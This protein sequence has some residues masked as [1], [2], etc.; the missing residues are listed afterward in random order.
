MKKYLVAFAAVGLYTTVAQAENRAGAI[1]LTPVVGGYHY[2][3]TQGIDANI[4]YGLKA[5]Y[6]ITDRFGM[7]ML[8]HYVH[9]KEWS[10]GYGNT[11][12]LVNYRVELLYHLFPQSSFVPFLAVGGGGAR[13][14]FNSSNYD[15]SAVA[16]YGIGANIAMSDTIALRADARM[17]SVFW[18]PAVVYNYEYTL[19]VN[20]QFG[21]TGKA[22]KAIV[23]EPKP[24]PAPAPKLTPPPVA[25]TKQVP[26]VVTEPER[27]TPV[28]VTPPPPAPVP[29]P[30]TVLTADP[31]VI[32]QSASSTLSWTA[33]NTTN[34]ILQPGIGPVAATGSM[35]VTLSVDTTYNLSCKGPGGTSD[36]SASIKVAVPVIL[37]SDN[38][39]VPD[40][41]D[42]CPNTPAGKKVASDGC[43]VPECKSV[44]LDLEFDTNKSIVKP[45]D[46][47][48]LKSVAE[49]LHSFPR[50]TVVIEGHTD[51][52]G[53]DIY[54]MKLSQRRA[55]AVRTFIIDQHGIDAGRLTAKGYGESKPL[56][57][58]INENGRSKN[59]RVDAIFSCPE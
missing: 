35:A 49:K 3:G 54:N 12:D 57:S 47:G 53:S 42:K 17:I 36:S 30:K 32:D 27:A 26:V 43:P 13:S 14:Y 20:F 22:A 41:L 40:N 8:L 44:S 58:N 28:P 25:T 18:N 50:S 33:K 29:P 34:C 38:D 39:G 2:D 31:A 6:N 23:T 46:H 37:D 45:K 52:V 5:G 16:S 9:T 1:N 51:S 24:E 7:E 59:R 48:K 21:G 19:G 55:D 10:G 4:L 56:Y 11:M 15:D